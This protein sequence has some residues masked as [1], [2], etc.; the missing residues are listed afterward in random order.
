MR[1]SESKVWI[2][3]RACKGKGK[4][5][6]HLRWVCPLEKRL[7]SQKVGTDKSGKR[8]SWRTS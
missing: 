2:R 5:T 4:T 8:Q 1:V 7:K 6:Y 3:K